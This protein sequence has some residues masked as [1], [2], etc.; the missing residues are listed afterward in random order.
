MVTL[1]NK[2]KFFA[3]VVDD[4][5]DLGDIVAEELQFAGFEAK[6][7]TRVT[8]AIEFLRANR[9]D[10]VVSD[11]RMPD[12]GAK[13]LLEAIDTEQISKP[14]VFLVVSGYSEVSSEALGGRPVTAVF[15]KPI[16]F[17][18]LVVTINQNLK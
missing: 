7:V 15:P 6:A 18:K 13:T 17:E 9:V 4:E 1:E 5:P 11:L 2:S 14:K 16:D 12:G 3:L 8:A 10:I